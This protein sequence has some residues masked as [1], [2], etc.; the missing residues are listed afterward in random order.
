MK[1]IENL[2][3][4]TIELCNTDEKQ[5]Q[6]ANEPKLIFKIG[7][8]FFLIHKFFKK[9]LDIEEVYKLIEDDDYYS[10]HRLLEK[11]YNFY[12]EQS[13]KYNF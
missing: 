8:N 4:E 11:Q 13:S 1:A 2:L 12:I 3:E 10:I 7:Y 5:Q 6:I 9:Y